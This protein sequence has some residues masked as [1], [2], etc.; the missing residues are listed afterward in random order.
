MQVSSASRGGGGQCLPTIR[1]WVEE[2]DMAAVLAALREPGLEADEV[3]AQ[4]VGNAAVQSSMQEE[5]LFGRRPGQDL[6]VGLRRTWLDKL[7]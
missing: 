7:F 4:L 2:V 5:P 1:L 6:V 3:A